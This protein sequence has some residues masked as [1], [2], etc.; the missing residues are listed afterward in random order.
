MSEKINF[1]SLAREHFKVAC[2]LTEAG[3]DRFLL[4]VAVKLRMAIEALAYELI[5]SLQQDA[6]DDTM[7]T[8]QPGKLIKELKKIDPVIEN[9]RSISVGV[10]GAHGEAA[11]QMLSL[12]TDARLTA[13]WINKNW[14]ALGSYLHERTIKKHKDGRGFDPVKA[15]IK[16]GEISFEIDRILNSALFATNL[17][18]SVSMNCECGFTIVR[19]EE[20]LRRDGEVD[21]A[22]CGAIWC[23]KQMEKEWR[24]SKLFHD[25]KCPKCE[26]KN[27]FPAKILTD[28]SEFTCKHCETVVVV[29]RDWIVRVKQKP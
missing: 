4:L 24:F 2:E 1:R 29:M 18:L 11:E 21:C 7:E 12:G 14:N 8:W 20:I 9:D 17:K 5:Q 25:F 19:R 13:S 27:K 6:G 16:M 23:A 26:T 3:D 22:N 15:R 10:E 28:G